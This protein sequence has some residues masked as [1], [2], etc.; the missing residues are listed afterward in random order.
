MTYL[1]AS[2]DVGV[3]STVACRLLTKLVRGNVSVHKNRG[4][5]V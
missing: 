1:G 5:V 4:G 3:S 2:D